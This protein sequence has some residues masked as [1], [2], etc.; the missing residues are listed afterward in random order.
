MV[1]LYRVETD[2]GQAHCHVLSVTM[3]EVKLHPHPVGHRV[4]NG[5]V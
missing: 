5:W 1:L 4:R 3:L 2:K